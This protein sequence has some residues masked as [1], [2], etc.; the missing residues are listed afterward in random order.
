[1]KRIV[2]QFLWTIL[3][4]CASIFSEKPFTEKVI[5]SGWLY[6]VEVSYYEENNLVGFLCYTKIPLL[7][8][9][10]IHTFYVFPQFRNQ[11]FG[12]KL[13]IHTRDLLKK[14]GAYRIYIQPGPFELQHDMV[15]KIANQKQHAQALQKLEKLYHA[16]GFEKVSYIVRTCA[17]IMYLLMGIDEDTTYLMVLQL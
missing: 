10:I 5:T 7:S 8:W 15:I 16:I 11:G 14:L 12:K 6:E 2:M 9:Y 13:L 3:I 17:T 1:M 4:T